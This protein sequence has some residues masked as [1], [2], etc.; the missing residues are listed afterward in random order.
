MPKVLT[1]T[2]KV[3]SITEDVYYDAASVWN[4]FGSDTQ[5][6][7]IVGE[8]VERA[9]M[10]DIVNAFGDDW[11]A[12]DALGFHLCY[13]CEGEWTNADTDGTVSDLFS[14]EHCGDVLCEHCVVYDDEE[15]IYLCEPC[16]NS[17]VEDRQAEHKPGCK[18]G[19]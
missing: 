15:D 4:A 11:E 16:Y 6:A 2:V 18:K 7:T 13:W 12:M 17:L 1:L 9:T 19:G 14:C 5:Q 10:R 8:S 3:Y